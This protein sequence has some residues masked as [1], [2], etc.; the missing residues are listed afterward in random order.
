MPPAAYRPHEAPTTFAGP[1][2]VQGVGEGSETVAR[3]IGIVTRR[4]DDFLARTEPFAEPRGGVL[5]HASAGYAEG[6]RQSRAELCASRHNER[7]AAMRGAFVVGAGVM[8]AAVVAAAAFTILVFAGLFSVSSGAGGG[9]RTAT[10]AQQPPSGTTPPSSPSTTTPPSSPSEA[11][12]PPSRS[13]TTGALSSSTAA[14]TG[15]SLLPSSNRV[16]TPRTTAGAQVPAP[17]PE[18][19]PPASAPAPALPPVSAP[20]LNPAGKAPPGQNR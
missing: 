11:I 15:R 20:N 10:L 13:D 5:G 18:S 17:P 1:T 2:A 9:H 6:L 16:A 8:G 3:R 7:R 19:A 4:D 14:Q 12:D